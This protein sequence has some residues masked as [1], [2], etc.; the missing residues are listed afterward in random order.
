V[1]GKCDIL[2]EFISSMAYVKKTQGKPQQ[3]LNCRHISLRV[4][5]ITQ[6]N[7][8]FIQRIHGY[9]AAKEC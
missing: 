8:L 4:M 1:E 3:N 6:S 2:M 7:L 5:K 9:V